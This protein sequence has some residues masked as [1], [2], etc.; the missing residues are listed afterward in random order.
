[1][2]KSRFWFVLA[3]VP[4]WLPGQLVSQES[5]EVQAERIE[6]VETSST[7]QNQNF[8]K[9]KSGF[10]T[11]IKL[12]KTKERYQSLPE[13]LE[14]EAGIKVRSFGGL[15]SYSTLSIR[16]TNPNQSR[17]Y[18]DGIPFN[19]TQS[20][21]VNLADL[22]FD[23]LDSV[24]V[25][26][27]GVSIGFAGSA[28]GGVVNLKTTKPKKETTRINLGAGSFHTGRAIAS[29]T[30]LSE[31]KKIGYSIFG[32]GE[33]SDQNFSFLND[34]GTI[35]LN[36]FDDTIDRRKNS[37][38]ERA[39]ASG[40]IYGS[41]GGT[42]LKLFL[43]LNHRRQGIP[44]PGSRQTEKTERKY[45]RLT[46]A[47]STDTQEFLNENIRLESKFYFT[48]YQ[49]EFRDPRSEFSSG[50]PNS[51]ARSETLGF[52]V[53]PS[54][55]LLDYYQII[56][57]SGGG[58][59][60][61]F[62]RDKRNSF[63]QVLEKEP[64]RNRTYW[65]AQLE[66]EIQLFGARFLLI[67][68]VGF[69]QYHDTWQDEFQSIDSSPYVR[70][71]TEFVNPRIGAL[72]KLFI[73]NTSK[74]SVKANANKASRIPSFLEV[75]GERGQILGNSKLLPEKSINHD[76]GMIWDWKNWNILSLTEI[77]YF[78]KSI[79]DMILFIPNSQ[80]SLRAENLDAARIRG[81]EFQQSLE[82]RH[83][84]VKMNYT[85]QIAK[86]ETDSP[87][88]KGKYL[89]LRPMHEFFGTLIYNYNDWQ[90]GGEFTYIGAVFRDRTNEYVNYLPG[91][92]IY[93]GFI[94]YRI[95]HSKDENDTI[96]SELKISLDIKNI[97]NKQF[98]DFIGYPLPG[99]MWFLN[100]SYVF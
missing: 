98:E 54:I 89:P 73:S 25:Y 59:K 80:F 66:D 78:Q 65:N 50:R 30:G 57:V 35:L 37:Q 32:L 62:R 19:N 92:D 95:A 79:D 68:G 72:W 97:T 55:Y 47:I 11:E 27:S 26:R 24:E 91:R 87:S 16:G 49:D 94:S 9:N 3:I 53:S 82:W 23:N 64:I 28:I 36:S 21:E 75:F 12:D 77:S 93:G 83:W 76:I 14:R 58:E 33:K 29:H 86:N 45:S 51:K 100:L 7:T 52:L 84:V 22:P 63:H 15:G 31:N 99:R 8:K 6:V 1:M 39:Q 71:K 20:G 4:A 60:E 17:Y 41:I 90:L 61:D 42:D 13:I 46:T 88:L 18:V 10:H 43:D 81:W 44:G 74:F 85:Y 2:K 48:G 69:D 38:F 34:H 67:P 40:S 56:R 70:K 5:Q 96:K